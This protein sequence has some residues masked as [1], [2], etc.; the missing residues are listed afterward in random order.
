MDHQKMT[1]QQ[2]PTVKVQGSVSD[3]FFTIVYDISLAGT[4][5]LIMFLLF[6]TL[7]IL[8]TL[9]NIIIIVYNFVYSAIFW[10]N[11]RRNRG[12]KYELVSMVVLFL[13]TYVTGEK[14]CGLTELPTE[15]LVAKGENFN[16][17]FIQN[18]NNSFP[19]I[20]ESQI[21]YKYDG[22][23]QS[24]TEVKVRYA[25]FFKQEQ[26]GCGYFLF[27]NKT[28]LVDSVVGY[29]DSENFYIMSKFNQIESKRLVFQIRGTINYV[30]QQIQTMD[31]TKPAK[32]FH[33][34]S[35]TQKMCNNIH[36]ILKA[37]H[38]TFDDVVYR[39]Q[40]D[41]LISFLFFD[42]IIDYP[43]NLYDKIIQE[44]VTKSM[45]AFGSYLHQGTIGQA[46]SEVCNYILPFIIGTL[47]S[48]GLNEPKYYE[49]ISK[50]KY[51]TEYIDFIDGL[52]QHGVFTIVA[53]DVQ[54]NFENRSISNN[55]D[56]YVSTPGQNI[57]LGHINRNIVNKGQNA[58]L[59]RVNAHT[60]SKVNF[61][62][63]D[64]Y[65]A[66]SMYFA[67]FDYFLL[68]GE[69][70]IL[71]YNHTHTPGDKNIIYNLKSGQDQ[72]VES[73]RYIQHYTYTVGYQNNIYDPRYR[74]LECNE[75]S[76]IESYCGKFAK[77]VAACKV[78]K[79]Q[80]DEWHKPIN[81]SDS[82][83]AQ[84]EQ[85]VDIRS[86]SIISVLITSLL[87]WL[88]YKFAK[89]V[90]LN[91]IN[92]WM[93]RHDTVMFD[94][95]EKFSIYTFKKYTKFNKC[96]L[97]LK[98]YFF[99]IYLIVA[100]CCLPCSIILTVYKLIQSRQF[101]K[102][103]PIGF[104]LGT[105]HAFEFGANP[106]SVF[107]T[108]SC[109]EYLSDQSGNSQWC[110]GMDGLSL[111]KKYTHT[112]NNLYP[113][114]KTLLTEDC[115]PECVYERVY[116]NKVNL[117]ICN[118]LMFEQM[119]NNK[120]MILIT[121]LQNTL[122]FRM[123]YIYQPFNKL[124]FCSRGMCG[125]NICTNYI[126]EL[127]DNTNRYLDSIDNSKWEDNNKHSS[128][129]IKNYL[130]NHAPNNLKQVSCPY[131]V[132]CKRMP[133]SCYR[134]TSHVMAYSDREEICHEIPVQS[135]HT[136]IAVF[137]TVI[138]TQP[139]V[140]LSIFSHM[141]RTNLE[142]DKVG[143]HDDGNIKYRFDAQDVDSHF[144]GEKFVVLFEDSA[145][146]TLSKHI[147][148]VDNPESLNDIFQYRNTRYVNVIGCENLERINRPTSYSHVGYEE[149]SVILSQ[150]FRQLGDEELR[151]MKVYI[152]KY[153]V[154][155]VDC[156]GRND[157]KTA[158]ITYFQSQCRSTTLEISVSRIK[159]NMGTLDVEIVSRESQKKLNNSIKPAAFKSISCAG[160][161]YNHNGYR[162]NLTRT[163]LQFEILAE[164]LHN[165]NVEDVVV[166]SANSESTRFT[167]TSI[168]EFSI[169]QIQPTVGKLHNFT[170]RQT[171]RFMGDLGEFVE[172]KMVLPVSMKE[173]DPFKT[174]ENAYENVKN[175]IIDY[176]HYWEY[177]VLVG[178][179]IFILLLI[180]YIK[181][182]V[183][184]SN[185]YHII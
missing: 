136:W 164:I 154:H 19:G 29:H 81:P 116:S 142:F 93:L 26:T 8:R 117:H 91:I 66:L 51:D 1:T 168:G 171:D 2:A 76:K 94:F 141:E 60:I 144:S 176:L 129:F 166:F 138:E 30:T 23:H 41:F 157:T 77:V 127:S 131:R 38:T 74:L 183:F 35:S 122:K 165:G 55:R 61:K 128:S 33:Y 113:D 9:I 4:I 71:A 62:V 181:S 5:L 147:F 89:H 73:G 67:R 18:F 184:S 107:Q 161:N 52:P 20:E 105:A 182:V 106:C 175:F 109:S 46:N 57:I 82:V 178:C 96:R 13:F 48:S 172:H 36:Y 152:S 102:Y 114:R 133:H 150:K 180:L 70:R 28:I 98:A 153:K 34:Q 185:K 92:I 110:D 97:I 112:F 79:N 6:C 42:Y 56:L 43:E 15:I 53:G 88:V 135:P 31:F 11:W 119:N 163:L 103:F 25:G 95:T 3:G 170:C 137:F 90:I 160:T 149:L 47:N 49:I 158:N 177:L 126:D 100:I 130:L 87:F 148:E 146:N 22:S 139:K 72:I 132:H 111:Y 64:F 167:S 118:K 78:D 39:K 156:V 63:I 75:V 58:V 86:F 59:G 120:I 7:H 12:R 173:F 65:A 83:I 99:P 159:Q 50:Y 84:V 54:I 14:I 174:I 10:F 143:T 155:E 21:V 123:N 162:V 151:K 85:A 44:I 32:T 121:G 16:T 140:Q 134:F 115:D 145:T 104:L 68:E 45:L 124:V 108:E 169:R 101:I 27:E 37:I 125:E 17:D 179:G 69:I 40:L 80:V 24:A